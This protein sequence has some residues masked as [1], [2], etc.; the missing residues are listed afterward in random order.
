MQNP[1]EKFIA[2]AAALALVLCAVSCGRTE[3]EPKET[4]AETH[5]LTVTENAPVT[6]APATEAPVTESHVERRDPTDFSDAVFIGD[7]RTEG[8]M[9]Y[10]GV[11]GATVLPA[12]GL[13]VET[14]FTKEAIEQDGETLTPADALKRMN[15]VGRIYIML[16]I[17]ELGWEYDSVF[18]NKYTELVS[19][20]KETCPGAAV[21]L[22]S[23]I[24]VTEERA[25]GDDIFNNENIAAYNVLIRGIA[26]NTGVRF[27]D[28]GRFLCPDGVLPEDCSFDGIHLTKPMCEKWLEALIEAS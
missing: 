19:Y 15:G 17:N 20:V 5:T 7:S 9:L 18:V 23:L 13:N 25:A 22:E 16:G 21:F 28:V 6:E 26:E 27:L 10:S 11:Q 3:S 8:F 4:A 2:A 1:P 12:R 14:F 24:P